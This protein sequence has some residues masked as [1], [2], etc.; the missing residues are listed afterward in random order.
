MLRTTAYLGGTV[1][2]AKDK[3]ADKGGMIQIHRSNY[4]Y[5]NGK[6]YDKRER[7]GM[8]QNP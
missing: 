2:L 3:R 5:S 4:D 7:E 1:S 6:G 8:I